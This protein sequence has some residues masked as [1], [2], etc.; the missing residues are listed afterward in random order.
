VLL[1]YGEGGS[2]YRKARYDTVFARMEALG[3]PLVGPSAPEGGVP[4]DRWPSELPTGSTTR[5]MRVDEL[6]GRVARLL[7]DQ[8]AIIF[9]GA[10]VSLGTQEDQDAGLGMPSS[11]KLAK[12]IAE[13]F[14]VPFREGRSELDGI[15][16]LAAGEASDVSSVKAFVADAILDRVKA[17]L[18]THRALARVAPPL[19]LTTNYDDLLRESTR[20]SRCPL[21][22]DCLP[23]PAFRARR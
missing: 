4:P 22:Q 12:M 19:V 9:L 14:D 1:G 7:K 11:A 6:A 8:D 2:P 17:P 10:G 21:R 16:A 20:R 3:L 23:G 18:R 5:G 13:E 15:A